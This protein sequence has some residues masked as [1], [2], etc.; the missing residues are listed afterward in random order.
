MIFIQA[1]FSVCALPRRTVQPVH[2]GPGALPPAQC[3]AAVNRVGVGV[4]PATLALEARGWSA[5]PLS[6][7]S[8]SLLRS[9]N[10]CTPFPGSPGRDQPADEFSRWMR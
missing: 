10:S 2:W 5:E 8:L 9:G 7:Y 4:T 1:G 3:P 6:H